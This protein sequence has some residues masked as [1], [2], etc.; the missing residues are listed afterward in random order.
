MVCWWLPSGGESLL[1]WCAVAAVH[2]G[3][4]L[5]KSI[6]KGPIGGHLLSQ[7]MLQSAQSRGTTV[8]PAYSFRR[9]QNTSG[10]WEVRRPVCLPHTMFGLAADAIAGCHNCSFDTT[11]SPVSNFTA[12]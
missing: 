2:D 10:Q 9:V 7:C 12:C 5:T 3:Y 8:R 1:L 11:L 6:V 4:L